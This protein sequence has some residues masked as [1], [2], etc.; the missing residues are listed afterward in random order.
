[1]MEPAFFEVHKDL[2]REGP[3][4]PEDVTWAL[5]QCAD[6]PE[7]VLDA[8][9]GPGADT[10]TLAQALPQAQITAVDLHP[11]FVDQATTRTASFGPRVAARVDDMFALDGPFDLIWCAGAAYFVGL[12]EALSRW[13]P[14]LTPGGIVAASEPVLPPGAGAAARAFWMDYPGVTD[15]AGVLAQ[16]R[17]AGFEP[18]ASRLISVP[19]WESYYTPLQARLDL[20]RADGADPSLARHIDEA[21]HEIDLWRVAPE[22]IAYLLVIAAR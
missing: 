20:L 18:T 15:T 5:G 14:N 11:G 19:A 8:A 3:G 12:T 9:C 21:Q 17:A 7:R 2:P 16:V 1:M 13:Q 22:Q 10:V 4:L 6:M